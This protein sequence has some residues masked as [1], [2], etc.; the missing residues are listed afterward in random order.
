MKTFH[1]YFFLVYIRYNDAFHAKSTSKTLGSRLKDPKFVIPFVIFLWAVVC[2]IVVLVLWLTGR[3][4]TGGSSTSRGVVCSTFTF[5]AETPLERFDKLMGLENDVSTIIPP[6][7]PGLDTC[8]D[9][10]DIGQNP[11][12]RGYIYQAVDKRCALLKYTDDV[13][14]PFDATGISYGQITACRTD[15]L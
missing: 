5:S 11:P 6:D 4:S 7:M 15:G 1:T 2:G 12:Y 14:A 13:Y 10:A 3:F 8:A 9:L